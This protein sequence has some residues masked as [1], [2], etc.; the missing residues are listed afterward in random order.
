MSV[1]TWINVAVTS[2]NL[3]IIAWVLVL[4]I[5]SRRYAKKVK[6]RY[7]LQLTMQPVSQDLKANTTTVAWS[8][9]ITKPEGEP[10]SPW[11]ARSGAYTFGSEPLGKTFIWEASA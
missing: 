10:E 9:T 8:L 4:H 5:R 7:N 11:T 3:A 1:Q 2:I 6:P